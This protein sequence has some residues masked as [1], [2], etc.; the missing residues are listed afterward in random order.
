MAGVRGGRG[1]GD[2]GGRSGGVEIAIRDA[3]VL[4]LWQD[5]DS[6]RWCAAL[7]YKPPTG[8]GFRM[9]FVGPGTLGQVSSAVAEAMRTWTVQHSAHPAWWNAMAEDWNAMLARAAR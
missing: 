8:D 4:R 6:R 2:G 9:P 3:H 5:D 1:A 7:D